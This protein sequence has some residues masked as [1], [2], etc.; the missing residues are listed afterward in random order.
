MPNKFYP[1][2]NYPEWINRDWEKYYDLA[3][4]YKK[5]IITLLTK[6]ASE[7]GIYS[8]RD[9]LPILFLFRHYA[10]LVFKSLILQK[11]ENASKN[12]DIV[13]LM[14]KAQQLHPNFELSEQYKKLIGFIQQLDPKGDAFKY[15]F[16]KDNEEF[17][18]CNDETC[19]KGVLL[20]LVTIG[21]TGFF[22]E[23]DK[24]FDSI[25]KMGKRENFPT[26]EKRR[27]KK[28]KKTFKNAR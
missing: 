22:Q 3:C 17:F 2:H 12:H 5:H 6:E 7:G 19:E 15:P 23:V 25:L 4:S 14:K 11:N 24:Y 8:E 26:V 28:N 27:G 9:I 20:S 18:V 13:S 21:I 1:I 16:S 10:E